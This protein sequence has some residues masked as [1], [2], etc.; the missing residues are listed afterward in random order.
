MTT[1]RRDGVTAHP[2]GIQLVLGESVVFHDG[3]G[4]VLTAAVRRD[5]DG[6]A[7]VVVAVEG[8]VLT[9]TPR[10]ARALAAALTGIANTAEIVECLPV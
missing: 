10:T 9:V 8:D 4:N 3:D 6:P 2:D 1:T 7:T 5:D